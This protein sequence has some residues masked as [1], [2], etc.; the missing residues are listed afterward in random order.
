MVGGGG[1]PPMVGV[2]TGGCGVGSGVAV[3]PVGVL[4]GRVAEGETRGVGVV[5]A[6]GTGLPVSTVAV[7]GSG[8]VGVVGS[9]FPSTVGDGVAV[10]NGTGVP[11]IGPG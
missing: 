2:D 10:S 8:G 1:Y 11:R 9:A 5:V 4:P 7:A 6:P 3:T